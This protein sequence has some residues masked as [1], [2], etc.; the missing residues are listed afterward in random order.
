MTI[1]SPLIQNTIQMVLI[2]H[3]QK[4]YMVNKRHQM[5]HQQLYDDFK[6]HGTANTARYATYFDWNRI[7]EDYVARLLPNALNIAFGARHSDACEWDIAKLPL[8][9]KRMFCLFAKFCET[10]PICDSAKRLKLKLS[11]SMANQNRMYLLAALC[12][13]NIKRLNNTETQPTQATSVPQSHLQ[14]LQPHLRRADDERFEQM[15]Q[16]QAVLQNQLT[17]LVQTVGTLSECV[18]K[19][20]KHFS[21]S[22]WSLHQQQEQQQQ[23]T[24]NMCEPLHTQHDKSRPPLANKQCNVATAHGVAASHGMRMDRATSYKQ[25]FIIQDKRR[26][27][28]RQ[29]LH[30]HRSKPTKPP[31]H[32]S[33]MQQQNIKSSEPVTTLPPSQ[34]VNPRKPPMRPSKPLILPPSASSA[35]HRRRLRKQKTK[36]KYQQIDDDFALAQQLQD[37]ER[38]SI[39][40][41]AKQRRFQKRN[42]SKQRRSNAHKDIVA[43]ATHSRIEATNGSKA[44]ASALAY[45]KLQGDLHRVTELDSVASLNTGQG[46]GHTTHEIEEQLSMHT[47]GDKKKGAT[48]AAV[49]KAAK[50]TNAVAK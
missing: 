48:N 25:A 6:Q 20:N 22:W 40:R 23:H 21:A 33:H 32:P 37:Q 17:S 43:D 26:A 13:S 11:R 10:Q 19:N 42:A 16:Q 47:K 7:G 4:R 8:R 31:L 39:G 45:D 38:R 41:N 46:G 28:T 50:K 27:A 30:L 18:K 1:E 12:E 9:R 3:L 5:A 2:Q 44:S 49:K 15:Q 35:A 36:A 29:H 14:Q 24:R 34:R